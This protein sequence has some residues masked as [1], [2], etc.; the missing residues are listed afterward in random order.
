MAD[1]MN[2]AHRGASA[3]VTDNSIEA[4][5]KA[6]E[7]GANILEMDVHA[8]I[9]GQV[10]VFHD[11]NVKSVSKKKRQIDKM[12]LM[13]IKKLNL[14][15]GE[16]IPMLRDVL[17]RFNGQCQFN[18]EIKARD[19]ALPA[20]K[21]VRELDMLDDVLFSSFDG[22]WLLT[23]KSRNKRVRLACISKDK[24]LNIIQVATSLKAEAIHIQD[25]ITSQELIDNAKAEELKVHV[26]T[27]D[28]SQKMKKFI[29]MGI[30]GIITNRPDILA[31]LIDELPG[32]K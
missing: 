16:E 4:F 5:Q 13:E 31:K 23:I 9:D 18:V 22:P 12:L 10:I 27:V 3:H 15:N 25:K 29:D 24:K 32:Y 1:I 11:D 30:D 17:E 21:I 2:I 26:W 14:K 6:I 20:F 19:A 28:K 8:T 7:M